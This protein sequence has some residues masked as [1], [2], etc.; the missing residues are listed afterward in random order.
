MLSKI[1]PLF[2][3]AL[4]HSLPLWFSMN[5]SGSVY[6][7][8]LCNGWLSQVPDDANSAF[9][10]HPQLK[11]G[12]CSAVL[13][14]LTLCCQPGEEKNA[15]LFLCVVV[16][17]DQGRIPSISGLHQVHW[18]NNL[19]LLWTGCF[20]GIAKKADVSGWRG[21]GGLQLLDKYSVSCMKFI[22]LIQT[23][24]LC[25]LPLSLTDFFFCVWT[26]QLVFKWLSDKSALLEI[27]N[28][29]SVCGQLGGEPSPLMVTGNNLFHC[30]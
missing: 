11:L 16:K 21:G 4:P 20:L 6:I 25:L 27:R 14:V 8:Y 17:L 9:T 30:A 28:A 19:S 7:S 5:D 13:L 29:N 12:H 18:S 26:V 2:W 1:A 3:S 22:K 24:P 10:A 15:V 23:T